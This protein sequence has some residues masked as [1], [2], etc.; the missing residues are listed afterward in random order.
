MQNSTAPKIP[1]RF[2]AFYQSDD[3]ASG[4]VNSV[5]VAD[6]F[7]NITQGLLEQSKESGFIEYIEGAPIVTLYSCKDGIASLSSLTSKTIA[8]ETLESQFLPEG[9]VSHDA[10]PLDPVLNQILL[11][12]CDFGVFSF[13]EFCTNPLRSTIPGDLLIQYLQA[14]KPVFIVVSG[15]SAL[16]YDPD[17]ID[18]RLSYELSN[19]SS[20]S[21]DSL[22]S[23]FRP[24]NASDVLGLCASLTKSA[25]SKTGFS[26]V[27]PTDAT[28]LS[29]Y[30]KTPFTESWVYRRSGCLNDFLKSVLTS[31]W[32]SLVFLDPLKRAIRRDNFKGWYGV[33]ED[34][35]DAND[36]AKYIEPEHLKRSFYWSDIQA[37]VASGTYRDSI[38]L[39]HGLAI[40]AV[41]SA[42]AGS[43]LLFVNSGSHLWGY[44]ELLAL[45]FVCFIVLVSNKKRWHKKWIVHRIIAEEIRG[46]RLCALI[47]AVPSFTLPK[48]ASSAMLRRRED[49]S[50]W[51]IHRLMNATELNLLQRQPL[52]ELVDIGSRDL[53][54][55]IKDQKN[56][57]T[58][59]DH[60]HHSMSHFLH[61]STQFAFIVTL[62][63]VVAH[64]F[65]HADWL[66]L[67]TAGLPALAAGLHAIST[68]S[69]LKRL[70][71]ISEDAAAHFA[72]LET[73]V[74]KIQFMD[75]SDSQKWLMLREIASNAAEKMSSIN[76]QWAYLLKDKDISLP[77]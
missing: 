29:F 37:N 3:Y 41:F 1:A 11:S 70:S 5:L 24:L 43:I 22:G 35:T 55:V 67:L 18:L 77:A 64:F 14:R 69:E 30:F 71:H 46:L 10:S 38:W 56:F 61:A 53:I 21:L 6:L 12:R 48:L 73:Q 63:A 17:L 40:L 39:L 19:N 31:S 8:C 15:P 34:I 66:L 16:V 28:E 54:Y 25:P 51:I 68:E 62:L 26:S 59:N 9:F 2:S 58:K 65:A 7:A 74:E 42:V 33:V 20:L 49:A 44:A 50:Q 75:V 47:G 60:N 23:I 32:R 72:Y 52:S 45:L 36:E 27:S 13:R 4:T 57:H 76:S